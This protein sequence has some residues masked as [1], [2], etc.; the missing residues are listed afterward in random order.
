MSTD[1]RSRSYSHASTVGSGSGSGSDGFDIT[2]EAPAI[3][4]E[5]LQELIGQLVAALPT[6][7][8]TAGAGA[9][10]GSGGNA[11]PETIAKRIDEQAGR[12][13]CQPFALFEAWINVLIE[14][15][16]DSSGD[17]DDF[18]QQVYKDWNNLAAVYN[19]YTKKQFSGFLLSFLQG[20]YEYKEALAVLLIGLQWHKLSWMTDQNGGVILAAMPLIEQLLATS[21]TDDAINSC[22]QRNCQRSLSTDQLV[23]QINYSL[24]VLPFTE[25]LKIKLNMFYQVA[26]Q[27]HPGL[28]KQAVN[29]LDLTQDESH[30]AIQWILAKLGSSDSAPV[31]N[32]LNPNAKTAGENIDQRVRSPLF[33]LIELAAEQANQN[34]DTQQRLV[35][36]AELLISH[37]ARLDEKAVVNLHDGGTEVQTVFQYA[38]TYGKDGDK[39]I[40]AK[41]LEDKVASESRRLYAWALL[42][43]ALVV[44]GIAVQ[45][46]H[47]PVATWIFAHMGFH[48]ALVGVSALALLTSVL[49]FVYLQGIQENRYSPWLVPSEPQADK[50]LDE[51]VTPSDSLSGGVPAPRPESPLAG[52]VSGVKE[53]KQEQVELITS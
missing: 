24:T 50:G 33:R 26:K 44:I 34:N 15:L 7:S 12:S 49:L 42:P 17:Q 43:L 52:G 5:G 2:S 40:L 41:Y 36:V 13:G 37:G 20:D 1:S 8:A 48:A 46:I 19:E 14:N 51:S 6:Q 18:D 21:D 10:A 25:E 16:P 30:A 3:S 11:E 4:P 9:G 47:S 53:T 29:T 35:A 39:T 27:V 38:G 32:S 23:E 31:Q 28:L 45:A 22:L